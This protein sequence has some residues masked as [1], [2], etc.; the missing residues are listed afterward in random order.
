M[1]Y[2]KCIKINN[3]IYTLK[4]ADGSIKEVDEE[5]VT[6]MISYRKVINLS[7]YIQKD[8]IDFY[9]TRESIRNYTLLESKELSKES[10]DAYYKSKLLGMCTSIKGSDIIQADKISSKDLVIT[11]RASILTHNIKANTITFVGNKPLVIDPAVNYERVNI[12]CK[13]AII[14]NRCVFGLL[15]SYPILLLSNNIYLSHEF[16]D[17]NTVNEIYEL[18][19]NITVQFM[20]EVADDSQLSWKQA[21]I[22]SADF[23]KQGINFED[24]YKRTSDIITNELSEYKNKI[25]ILQCVG[26]ACSMFIS[27]EYKFIGLL[28]LARICLDNY[29]SKGTKGYK[30]LNELT[31]YLYNGNKI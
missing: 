6:H 20:Y 17:L 3:N 5:T 21:V 4:Y 28:N 7:Y 31:N 14:K 26:L 23:K 12:G 27:T 24:V 18:Y 13:K 11:D 2:A 9:I 16:I 19:H 1:C 29:N 22:I 30:V 25:R 8:A 15:F 10:E